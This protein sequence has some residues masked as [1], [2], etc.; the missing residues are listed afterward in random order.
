MG[1][2]YGDKPV[3]GLGRRPDDRHAVPLCHTCHMDQHAIGELSFWEAVGI[4]PLTVAASLYRLSPNIEAMR[5][6][7]FVAIGFA[8]DAKS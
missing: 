7:C 4:A 6:A 3:T 1:T 8:K 2:L 5:A